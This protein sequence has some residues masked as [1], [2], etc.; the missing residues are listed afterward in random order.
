[1]RAIDNPTKMQ[2]LVWTGP[3]SMA[4]QTVPV[5][6]PGPNEVLLRVGATGICGSELSGFLGHSSLRKPPLIMGHE[7]VGTIAHIPDGTH[8]KLADNSDLVLGQRVT[9][10]PLVV[11]GECRPVP[12]G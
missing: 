3:R 1:M 4:M 10:N 8:L 2:A 7:T 11:C 6:Q 12:G 5:P 9:V